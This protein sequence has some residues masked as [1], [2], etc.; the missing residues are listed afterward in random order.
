MADANKWPIKDKTEED[1]GEEEQEVEET[2]AADRGNNNM[3]T[4]LMAE[5]ASGLNEDDNDHEEDG[6]VDGIQTNMSWPTVLLP[7]ENNN[8]Q[9]T[10]A[11]H[12]PERR[13]LEEDVVAVV[14][15]YYDDENDRHNANVISTSIC[16]REEDNSGQHNVEECLL[17]VEHPSTGIE[18]LHGMEEVQLRSSGDL[19]EEGEEIDNEENVAINPELDP[20]KENPIK[21]SVQDANKSPRLSAPHLPPFSIPSPSAKPRT[22]GIL[23]LDSSGKKSRRSSGFSSNVE[24]RN[25]PEML[26]EVIT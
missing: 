5:A 19:K 4:V 26:G 2:G 6:I 14:D 10:A 22:P 16:Q 15:D 9:T 24:F 25:D 1:D 17:A 8:V 3:S 13:T 12:P 21:E 11:G 7:T 18:Q 23:R 20:T